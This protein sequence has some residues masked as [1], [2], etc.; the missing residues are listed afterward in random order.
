MSGRQPISVLYLAG[1]G[2]S[3]SSIL[4]NVLGQAEGFFHG[5]EI[6]NIW[7]DGFVHDRLCGCGSPFTT[8]PFWSAVASRLRDSSCPPPA[9]VL[10][11]RNRFAR[12]RHLAGWVIPG[13]SGA[14]A[15]RAE[16]LI[17]CLEATY[18]AIRDES[19][20]EVIVDST[21][22][23][24]Y[25][26]LLT[27]APG[28]RLRVVHLVR[29]PRAVAFSWSR[30]VMQE[31]SHGVPMRRYDVRSSAIRWLIEN[32]ATER[33]FRR[34]EPMMRTS[35]EAFTTDP[36]S[37]VSSVVS[38]ATEGRAAPPPFDDRVVHIDPTH[39]VWGNQSRFLTG[40][41]DIRSD[42]RWRNAMDDQ[43]RRSVERL[44]A[45][46]ARRYGYA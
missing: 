31:S 46:L 28:I 4:G 45:P 21:M 19:G 2:R 11:E 41:V 1:F 23:P 43:A 26:H 42:E 33:L 13:V 22:S 36:A 14:R 38:F 10:A 8:C 9:Q 39:S 6:R 7:D 20:A 44:T 24:V 18:R 29:D 25:G 35:Y 30:E 34:Y 12:T 5:G 37:V 15:R 17:R 3:G 32:G 27:M 40:D 16:P